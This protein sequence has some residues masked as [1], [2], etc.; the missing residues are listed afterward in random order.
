MSHV[1]VIEE[2]L[3]DQWYPV[4]IVLVRKIGRLRLKQWKLENPG[5][6]FRLKKYVRAD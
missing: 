4:H 1:W 3:D 6:T 5:Y 2:K